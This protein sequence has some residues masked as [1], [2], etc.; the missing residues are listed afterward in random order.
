MNEWATPQ[1]GSGSYDL[2]LD[3]TGQRTRAGLEEA[4]R[5]AVRDGRLAP[6]A[7]LPS[8][9]VLAHDLGLARNT[10]AHAYGQLVAEGWLTARQGSGTTVAARPAVP[11]R[12]PAQRPA[13]PPR[14]APTDL[15]PGRSGLPYVLWPGSPDLASFPRTAWLRAARR[16]LTAAPNEA[17]G[18]TDPRGRPELRT[19]LADYLARVRGVR[20][21]PEHLVV[22]TGYTQAVGLLARALHGR[23]ARRAAVEAVGLPDTPTLLRAAG[24]EPVALPVDADGARVEDLGPGIPAVLLTPAHQFPLGV[25]LSPARRT[26]VVAWARSTGGIVVE[27]DYDGE[28]RYD[29]QPVAALQALAPDHVVYA[30][31]A[32]KSLAPGLRLA[33]LAVPPHLLEAVVREKRLA[34]HQSGVIDQLTLA[35]FIRAGAYDRHVRRVRMRYRARRDRVV[36]VLAL[37]APGV[38]VSGIAAGLHAVLDLPPDGAPLDAVLARAHRLGLAV[39]ALT[40]FGS[41]PS[42]PP[43]LVVGYGTPPDH[44]FP[45]ALGLLCDALTAR[46]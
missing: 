38:R 12:R 23:G 36:E 31:T 41:A 44:A 7:R 15:V 39:P 17:F 26:A 32:S 13:E 9:R 2:L 45:T 1:R 4:L 25:S 24:L 6:G 20:T 29:R 10:V 8:S 28:F 34:D 16:A 14:D 3:L 43:A 5:A 22:C 19:A 35:E 21:D 37:R 11:V 42:H 40:A 27:D 46:A 30:G 18:Y 33:W